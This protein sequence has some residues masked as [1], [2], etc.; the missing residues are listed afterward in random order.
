MRLLTCD[1]VRNP[2]SE[3]PEHRPTDQKVGGSNPSERAEE[4]QVERDFS[5]VELEQVRE[6][7][8]TPWLRAQRVERVANGLAGEQPGQ[9]WSDAISRALPDW[10]ASVTRPNAIGF[11]PLVRQPVKD[12]REHIPA[13]SKATQRS[14]PQ[15][16]A[17]G[18]STPGPKC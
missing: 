13:V 7:P 8:S 16:S 14:A 12:V 2:R 9:R 6:N 18:C 4:V 5:V 17:T 1:N 10:R 11:R 15:R 3:R